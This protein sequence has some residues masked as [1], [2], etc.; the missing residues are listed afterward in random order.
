[1]LFKEKWYSWWIF[2]Y[3]SK[4]DNSCVLLF[5]F[6]Q[7]EAPSWPPSFLGFYSKREGLPFKSSVLFV[8]VHSYW[9]GRETFWQSCPAC[10]RIHCL[11]ISLILTWIWIWPLSATAFKKKLFTN[12]AKIKRFD[13]LILFL[14]NK[15]VLLF[16]FFF[17]IS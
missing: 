13:I 8:S 9:Q 6:L 5:A 7:T 3:F 1:M 10:K 4:G 15:D 12:Y 11:Y 16:F 17:C 14:T 2:S